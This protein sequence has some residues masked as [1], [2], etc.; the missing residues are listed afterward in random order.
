MAATAK[1]EIRERVR[2][3][4][5]GTFNTRAFSTTDA[6]T[7]SGIVGIGIVGTMVVGQINV[8]NRDQRFIN[9]IPDKVENP[10]TEK[11]K[12]Y[13]YKRPGVEINNTPASGSVGTAIRLWTAQGTGGSVISAFG[14]SN[15]TVYNTT[16]SIGSITG[17]VDD[18]TETIIGTTPNL[19]FATSAGRGY[20]YPEGGSMTEITSANYPFN[21]AGQTA[22][23]THVHLDGYTFRMTSSGRIYNSDVGSLSAWSATNLISAQMF[24]DQGVGLARYKDYIVAFGRES[25]EFFQNSNNLT[26]SPLQRVNELVVRIGAL[27]ALSI[28]QMED[29]IAWVA[30]TATGATSV[31]VMDGAKPKRIS[32]DEIDFQLQRRGDSTVY[33]TNCKM[34]GKTLLFITIG[35]VSYVYCFED[36]VWHSWISN[37]AILWHMMA[38]NSA[39]TSTIYCISR[40]STSGIV[41]RFNAVTP[42]YQDNGNSYEFSVTTSKV[43]MDTSNRKFLHR[44]RVV[45]DEAVTATTLSISW[46]DDDY[47]TFT[48]VRTVAMTDSDRV[49]NN[50]G[51]FRRRAFRF[52]NTS[53]VPLR[54]EAMELEYT[55]GLH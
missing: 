35:S 23:G 13:V 10:F 14:A 47:E 44:L 51:V 19:V 28:T 49:L 18:I 29:T 50:L 30:S 8:A 22:V 33:A 54:L 38:A 15:S 55:Q 1:T 24:P 41:Y 45:G 7:S 17:R 53:S 11:V 42:V 6:G 31:Y 48:T 16:T 20:F 2:I 36:N 52:A 4:L 12:F 5:V 37:G 40:N 39:A 27:G 32:T 46:S 3:P 9:A 43:D 34:F 21:I 26:G 25:V